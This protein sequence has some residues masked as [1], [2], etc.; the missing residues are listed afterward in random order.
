[1]VILTGIKPTESLHLG[2]Y[3]GAIRP[4]LELMKA[5]ME[6]KNSKPTSSFFFIADYHALTNINISQKNYNSF[7]ASPLNSP[8]SLAPSSPTSSHSQKKTHDLK[9]WSYEITAALMACG[10]NPEKTILYRQSDIPHLFELTW[11]LSCFTPKGL[12]NRS[13]AYKAKVALNKKAS[14]KDLDF[15]VNMAL[16]SYPILMASDILAFNANWVPVGED[17]IQHV[18]MA[19][20]IAQKFNHFYGKILTLPKT[21]L[22][23]NNQWIP[24][25]DGKK[26][27][28]SY[29][30]HIPLFCSSEKLKKLI[31]K[32]KTDSSLPHEPKDPKTSIPF[33]LFEKLAPKEEIH[34]LKEMYRKGISWSEVKEKTYLIL[35]SH[36]SEAREKFNTLMKDTN[37]I[38]DILLQG[39]K[40]AKKVASKTLNKVRLALGLRDLPMNSK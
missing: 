32:I 4:Y 27:S 9:K 14:K 23:K 8:S 3:F 5:L 12:L 31:M 21:L 25:I 34:D 22:H 37:A 24:G 2:N 26:M 7:L 17:Q 15:D 13:H 39:S 40:K 38:E 11:I 29:G 10:I 1:M 20:D 36:L 16:Y 18:E 28:K 35:E 33:Q 6:G 19:R 30:N